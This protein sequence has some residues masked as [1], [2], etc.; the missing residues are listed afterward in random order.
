MRIKT[1]LIVGVLVEAVA[2][3]FVLAGMV[4]A[5]HNHDDAQTQDRFSNETS[6]AAFQLVSLTADYLLYPEDQ[7]RA[8]RQWL[9]RWRSLERPLAQPGFA[10]AEQNPFVAELRKAHARARSLFVRAMEIAHRPR[11]GGGHTSE[12]TA[13]ERRLLAQV[14][15]LT[16]V[17]VSQASLLSA[18][19]A[20]ALAEAKLNAERLVVA[21]MVLMAT[22]A[23][24]LLVAAIWRV[25][26][27]RRQM[28]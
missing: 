9:S 13:Q 8:E 18:Q 1:F 14:Q 7:G 20:M 23:L 16:Q 6:I 15:T 24:V 17:M 27:V 12:L 21:L 28:I 26:I 22:F 4:L 2:V 11:A 25:V 19:S 3:V 5:S 10:E